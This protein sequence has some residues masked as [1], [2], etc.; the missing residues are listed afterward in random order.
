MAEEESKNVDVVETPAQQPETPPQQELPEDKTVVAPAPTEETTLN[1]EPP[2]TP[3]K[4]GAKFCNRYPKCLVFRPSHK[5]ATEA[6]EKKAMVE[7]KRVEDVL[8]LEEMADKSEEEKPFK[9]SDSRDAQLARVEA[10][11]RLSLIKAWEESEKCK[12]ENKAHKKIVSIEVWEN[13]KKAVVEAE[14]RKIEENLEKKKAEYRE[15]MKNKVAMIHKEAEERKAMVEAKRGE[16]VLKLE[17]TAAKC[18]AAG[19]PPKKLLG[20]F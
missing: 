7:A 12:A 5:D 20:L 1:S 10:E 4:N 16:D 8:K 15:K 11:K 3:V 6:E 9:G 2:P 17:E 14:L 18:R 13:S 19:K